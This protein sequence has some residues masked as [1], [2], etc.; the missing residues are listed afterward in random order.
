MDSYGYII[1][2]SKKKVYFS[3]D[4]VNIPD[5]VLNQLETNQLDR[6]YQDTSSEEH[7]NPTHC[8]FNQL[9]QLVKE[10][11]RH[12]VYCVHLDKDFRKE[13]KEAGFLCIE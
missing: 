6:I 7:E 9:K 5:E 11:Y 3:G 2:I 8:S 4:A 12:K 1:E 13:I 10:E